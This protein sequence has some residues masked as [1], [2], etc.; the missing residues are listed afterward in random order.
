MAAAIKEPHL[1]NAGSNPLKL[2]R[3]LEAI[4]SPAEL[5]KVRQEIVS[6]VIGL[7]RLG[8][9]QCEFACGLP[10]THWRQRVSRFYYGAYNVRRAVVLRHDGSFS[11]DS[12]DHK[13]IHN[14][15]DKLQ[16]SEMYKSKFGTLRDDRNLADYNH[17]A[18]ESELVLSQS[19]CELLVK[20]FLSD[21]KIYLN[22]EGVEL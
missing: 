16:N 12:S 18:I 5:D 8:E 1:F 20:A 3:N 22:S 11:T 9:S 17:L 4:L 10:T 19:D 14:I 2:I 7:Y 13:N 15:P 21:A 6:N